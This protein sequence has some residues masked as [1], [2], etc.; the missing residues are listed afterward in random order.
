MVN[1]CAVFGC[2]NRSNREKDK[3]Y[4]RIPAIV[5]RSNAKKRALSIE[6]RA[7]WLSRI[8]REDL[9]ADPSEFHRVC[10]DHFISGK[11]SSIYDKENPD[12]APNQN[13]GYDFRGVSVTSN[14]RYERS[15]GRIEKRRRSECASA[16]LELSCHQPSDGTEM[17]FI[18][19]Y[20]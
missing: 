15:Q 2:S 9:G 5:T 7:T 4:F 13:L 1:F 16:L 10:G 19:P 18:K 12:W 6:R 14:E 20:Q 8:R 17:L 11:P 3:S